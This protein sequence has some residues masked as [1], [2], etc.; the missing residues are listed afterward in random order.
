LYLTFGE[1]DMKILLVALV[2]L[3]GLFSIPSHAVDGNI[4][5]SGTVAS[6]CSFTSASAG[7]L[8]VSGTS[9]SSAS[10]GTIQVTNNDAGAYDLLVGSTTLSTSPSGESISSIT[11]TPTVTG[12]NA[13]IALP[14]TLTNVGVD[15]VSV[16][17]T[18]GTL[19]AVA[20][21]GTYIVTQVITCV[22]P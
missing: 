1:I 10:S 12:V 22:T 5:F 16:A 21:A 7:T 13:G 19:D 3:I 6:S 18:A 2:S 8:T 11:A 20:T 15:T 14:S 9:I 17:L 4:I